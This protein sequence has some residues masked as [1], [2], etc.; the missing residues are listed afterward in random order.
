MTYN[1]VYSAAGCVATICGIMLT[2]GV[3][4]RSPHNFIYM[5]LAVDII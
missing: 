1:A 2:Y 4:V 5:V 3:M